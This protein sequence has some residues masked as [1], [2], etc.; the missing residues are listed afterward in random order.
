MSAPMKMRRVERVS[1]RRL[2]FADPAA[3]GVRRAGA[4]GGYAQRRD[5]SAHRACHQFRRLPLASYKLS[6][7]AVRNSIAA[8]STP[9]LDRSPISVRRI[10]ALDSESSILFIE[11]P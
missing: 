6:V 11:G 4:G 1:A 9:S 8:F 2:R 7:V 3:L 5:V 10:C